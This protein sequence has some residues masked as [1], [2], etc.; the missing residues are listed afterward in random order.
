MK[1]L[2]IDI[3][4]N[5]FF[6]AKLKRKKQH[7]KKKYW[8]AVT[9]TSPYVF[10]FPPA[11]KNYYHLSSS[12]ANIFQMQSLREDTNRKKLIARF[13]FGFSISALCSYAIVRAS[14]KAERNRRTKTTD[15]VVKVWLCGMAI[16]Y[17][18]CL[19]YSDNSFSVTLR[20]YC[21]SIRHRSYLFSQR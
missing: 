11:F 4:G 14:S 12:M 2:I 9:N 20:V 5:Q 13:S 21:R 1:N 3:Q 10:R 19:I 17:P 16:G 8:N 6:Y 7:T 18:H 15:K